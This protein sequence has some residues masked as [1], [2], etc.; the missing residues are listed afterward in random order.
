[1]IRYQRQS[2]MQSGDRPWLKLGHIPRETIDIQGAGMLQRIFDI[3]AMLADVLVYRSNTMYDEVTISG[4]LYNF[5]FLHIFLQELCDY[6][7]I[8]EEKLEAK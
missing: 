7:L 2:P 4:H 6:Y 5:M 3:M 8:E 1:M